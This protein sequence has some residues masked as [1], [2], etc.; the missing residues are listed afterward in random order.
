MDSDD[1]TRVEPLHSDRVV[2]MPESDV[3]DQIMTLVEAN[4][5]LG[6]TIVAQADQIVSLC[7]ENRELR[8]VQ[9]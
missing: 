2:V 7:K 5:K 6:E 4:A 9:T 3:R 1:A 8:S